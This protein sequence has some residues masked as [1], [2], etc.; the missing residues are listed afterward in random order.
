V[1]LPSWP[2]RKDRQNEIEKIR[3]YVDNVCKPPKWWRR[4]QGMDVGSKR[5]DPDKLHALLVLVATRESTLRPWKRHR[6]SPDIKANN[7]SW[8]QQA[9]R[10]GWTVVLDYAGGI[11]TMDSSRDANPYYANRHRWMG[12]GLYGQ[13]ASI[14]VAVLD[15]LA[16]PEVLCR[17]DL[18]TET[19][20]RQLRNA[21]LKLEAGVTCEG[22]PFHG[23]SPDGRAAWIDAH[24]AASTGRIC[25]PHPRDHD[26]KTRASRIRVGDAH[27]FELDPYEGIHLSWLGKTETLQDAR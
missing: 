21:W 17:T 3:A 2:S 25:G 9:K 11:R 14:N 5:C 1:C 15:R 10:Y 8:F 27:P 19:Y 23:S 16:P 22:K 13:N 24:R 12:L 7:S 4:G 26:F 20:L 18:A 6:L